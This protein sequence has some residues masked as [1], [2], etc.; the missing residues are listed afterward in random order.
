MGYRDTVMR[1]G[2]A[3]LG[4]RI[5]NHKGLTGKNPV[6]FESRISRGKVGEILDEE[7]LLTAA[8][9]DFQRGIAALG[10]PAPAQPPLLGRGVAPPSHRPWPRTRAN[11]SCPPPFGHGVLPASAPDLRRG[12]PP[13][14]RAERAPGAPSDFS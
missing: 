7:Y 3:T 6:T 4:R 12:V 1:T 2:Q 13:F 10:P 9:P 14:H 8:L 5:C 11:S